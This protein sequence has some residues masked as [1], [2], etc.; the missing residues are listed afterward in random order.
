MNTYIFT[1]PHFQPLSFG[2]AMPGAYLQFFLSETDTPTP[3]YSNAELSVSLGP[4][5]DADGDGVFVVIYMDPEVT[6]RVKLFNADDTL[7]WDIDP[8]TPPRDYPP[9]TVV[10]YLGTEAQRDVAYPPALWQVLDGSNG[11]PDGRDRLPMIAGGTYIAGDTGGA[12]TNATE[13]GG[14]VAAGVTGET[15]LDSTNMP[16]HHHRLYVRQSSTLRGNTHGFG[17]AGTAGLEGQVIDDAPYGYEDDAPQSSGNTLVEDTG[18][19][20]PEGH[21]HT[22]PAIPDH[23]HPIA[24]DGLPPF[25]AMWALMR[26][27]P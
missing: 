10:W 2:E 18:T 13:D 5:V 11:T 21:T 24:G 25:V 12:L 7:E 15:V 22:T 3:V 20:D 6:Y 27:V 8:Y 14:A 4:E 26:R 9:R 17:F 23:T 16:V 19:A 1:N